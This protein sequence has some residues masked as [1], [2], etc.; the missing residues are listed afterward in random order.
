MSTFVEILKAIGLAVL[1]FTFLAIVGAMYGVYF[2]RKISGW[3]QAR[4]GPKHVGPWGL[5]QTIADTLK[6]LQ[7]EHITPRR[8][9]AMI[10]NTA[11]LIVAVA[12]LLDWVVIPFGTA[13]GRVLVVR[14]INIGIVYFS[15]MASLTVIGILA[16][17][18]S[19]NNKYALLGGLRAASQMISYEIP[20]ALALLWVAMLAGTLS[21]V[22]I[23]EAQRGGWFL[24]KVPPFG[25]IAALVFLIAATAEVNR[26]PFDLPEAESELVAGY[27]AEYTGMRFALFQLG[28]YAEM[29]AMAAVAS[30][31][32]LGGWLEPTMPQWVWALLGLGALALAAFIRFSALREVLLVRPIL[33]LAALA[34]VLCGLMVV[35]IGLGRT[36]VL[37]SMLWFFVK[38]FGLVFFLMWMRWTY[39][40]LRLD[41]LLNLSWKVL[42]P[43]GL[44]NLLI[45]GFLLTV[46]R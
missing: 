21:T 45:T 16:A 30:I 40:R 6:L 46:A 41:Q 28:E 24:F 22:G 9:D 15:A 42:L 38:M 20:L 27:F 44:L 26:V 11:P 10:F 5:L 17:G 29:F 25:L 35:G 12:G 43:V 37:P 18:W 14:D 7:K 4:F 2:E 8:A 13:F 32:F 3:I 31:L 39:P 36:P 34:A 23:I 33:A 19:S 1:V